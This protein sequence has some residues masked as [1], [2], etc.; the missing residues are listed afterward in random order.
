MLSTPLLTIFTF[1]LPLD[2]NNFATEKIVDYIPR[3]IKKKSTTGTGRDV[4]T[5]SY[6]LYTS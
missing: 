5:F 3:K 2:W 6:F 1:C 4:F